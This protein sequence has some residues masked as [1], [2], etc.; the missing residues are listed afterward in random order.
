MTLIET[1]RNYIASCP[2]L[3]NNAIL[4][5]D[6]LD[7]IGIAYTIDAIPSDPI[8]KQYADG[9]Q[10]RQFQ[11]IFASR[12]YYG[13]NVLENL[14]NSGFYENFVDWIEKNNARGLSRFINLGMDR[15]ALSIAIN[16]MPYV[17]DT[18]ENT[19]RYQ[20]QLSLQYYQSW[21]YYHG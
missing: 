12:Q 6:K 10:L 13:M 14:E 11:F 18:E 4:G 15:K 3:E 1:V 8:I 16:S 17:Y 5:I 7:S 19:A 20:V 2:L 9:G 21:R